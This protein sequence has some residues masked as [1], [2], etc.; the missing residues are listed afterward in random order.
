MFGSCQIIITELCSLLK[1]YYSIHN[2]IRICKRGVVNYSF[3]YSTGR[4]E[5]RRCNTPLYVEKLDL[6]SL[7]MS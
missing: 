7:D 6:T 3:S 1:I 4:H 5:S 2:S